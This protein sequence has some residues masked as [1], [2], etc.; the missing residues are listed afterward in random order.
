MKIAGFCV[1][2]GNYENQ[3]LILLDSLF[4]NLKIKIDFFVYYNKINIKNNIKCVKFVKIPELNINFKSGT[5]YD[6]I[7][8][9][10]LSKIKIFSDLSKE[11]DQVFNID[12]DMLVLKNLDSVFEKYKEP[13]LYGCLEDINYIRLYERRKKV[14]KF[15]GITEKQYIN[16][17]FMILN[18][19]F[20][21]NLDEIKKFFEFCSFSNCPEQDYLNWKFKDKIRV[22][23]N[24]VN[25]NR[26]LP[27]EISPYIV[28]YLGFPKPWNLKDKNKC[29][30][31]YKKYL[32]Y[33]RNLGISNF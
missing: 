3:L 30:I 12:L 31:F 7:M 21:F 27:F 25:W 10:I 22:M 15:I 26:F 4:K 18:F 2:D 13:Y 9:L 5:Q 29:D 28:H 19:P 11:Y 33:A 14:L 6:K 16:A 8:N 20:E 23:P 24:Y 1:V 17:G 32:N